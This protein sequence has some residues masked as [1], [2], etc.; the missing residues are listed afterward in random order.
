M[1]APGKSLNPGAA[2]V[3]EELLERVEQRIR[4]AGSAEFPIS[5]HTIAHNLGVE[6]SDGQPVTRAAITELIRRGVPVGADS[7]GYFIIRTQE[8]LDRYVA[9]LNRRE[10]GIRARRIA[11]IRAFEEGVPPAGEGFRWIPDDPEER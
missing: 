3:D 8:Q 9:D 6:D 11:V 5:S 7:T 10:W 2:R 1:S 4:E